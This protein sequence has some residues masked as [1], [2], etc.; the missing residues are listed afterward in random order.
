M[1]GKLTTKQ[2]QAELDTT[3]NEFRSFANAMVQEVMKHNVLIYALLEDMGKMEKITCVNC[4]DEVARPTLSELEQN[5]DCPSCG[6]NLFGTEQTSLDNI[7][8]E[9]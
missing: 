9:E 6:K 2:L 7:L 3:T 4:K 8:E 1:S 5:D